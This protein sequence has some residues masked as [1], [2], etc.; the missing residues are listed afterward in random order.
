MTADQI[1]EELSDRNLT[2]VAERINVTTS[3]LSHFM[4]RRY[5]PESL[6]KKLRLY[7]KVEESK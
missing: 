1:R 6:L 5:E 2:R 4:R 7:L 3:Y